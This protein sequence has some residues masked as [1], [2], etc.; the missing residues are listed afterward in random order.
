MI[1][2][3]TRMTK[4]QKAVV[5]CAVALIVLAG[6]YPPWTTYSAE[7]G[8]S[9]PPRYPGEPTSFSS[10]HS[11]GHHWLFYTGV[12]QVDIVRL[13]VEWVLIAAVVACLLLLPEWRNPSHRGP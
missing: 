1:P 6:L 3:V 13:L 11:L 10:H 2:C 4:G 9:G 8:R 7:S 5:Y 12:G